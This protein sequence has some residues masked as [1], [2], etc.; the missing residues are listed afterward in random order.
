[1][2]LTVRHLEFLLIQLPGVMRLL[3]IASLL[4]SNVGGQVPIE[5]CCALPVLSQVVCLY[6]SWIVAS[7][8]INDEFLLLFIIINKVVVCEFADKELERA[9]R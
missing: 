7:I 2:K 9:S 6:I 5:V 3:I 1:M 4:Q 8:F